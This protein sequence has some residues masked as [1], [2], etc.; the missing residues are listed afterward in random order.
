MVFFL[1][2]LG[3]GDRYVILS[4]GP[5]KQLGVAMDGIGYNDGTVTSFVYSALNMVG[6]AKGFHQCCQASWSILMFVA[7]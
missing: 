3:V 7:L 6:V 4:A 5:R 2:H 1:V